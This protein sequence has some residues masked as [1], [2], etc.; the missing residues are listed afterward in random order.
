M[1]LGIFLL[2][3]RKGKIT[4]FLGNWVLLF[5]FKVERSDALIFY[6]SDSMFKCD[7]HYLEGLK[8]DIFEGFESSELQDNEGTQT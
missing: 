2:C 4:S 3:L 7:G 1:C 6:A 5:V 8:V